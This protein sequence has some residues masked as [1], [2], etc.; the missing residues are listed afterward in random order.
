MGS[1]LRERDDVEYIEWR[2]FCD[3]LRNA[4]SAAVCARRRPLNK[5]VHIVPLD[6]TALMT[7]MKPVT[8]IRLELQPSVCKV[9]DG[10]V[11]KRLLSNMHHERYGTLEIEQSFLPNN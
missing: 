9:K 3:S 1:T 10:E 2:M 7:L 8:I 11:V 5:P 4:C 6:S